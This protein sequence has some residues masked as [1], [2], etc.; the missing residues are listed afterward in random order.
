MQADTYELKQVMTPERRYIIPT[1]QRDYEW[2]EEGQWNLLF[3]DLE[4]VADRLAQAR[5]FAE[6]AGTPVLKA[7]KSVAP[8]FLGAI[9]CD[10]LPSP[11]GGL[12]LRAVIDGQQRL[13]TLQLLLRGVL[14]VLLEQG[15]SRAKQVRRL[16]ENPSDVVDEPHERF[17]LWPR[18]KDRDVW[19]VAMSDEPAPDGPHLYLQARAFFSKRARV[20]MVGEDGS[21]RTDAVVDALVGLFKLVVIDLEDNDDA[22][23]IFEVLNGRQTPLSA[24]DLVKNLLFLRGE[25]ADEKELE[26]LYDSYWAEFDEEWWKQKVGIGHA[27]RG[28]R[29]VLLSAWLTAASGSEVNVGH[30]Y[31]EV[32]TYLDSGDRK[33]EEILEELYRYGQAYKAVYGSTSVASPILSKAY[34]RL[35]LLKIQTAAPLFL[36]LR[37]VPSSVLSEADHEV[38]VA[39]IESWTL[40]R[41]IIGANT[42]GYGKA[43]VD[44]LK[45]AR[46]AFEGG[47]SIAAAIIAALRSGPNSLAWPSDAEVVAAFVS[48]KFYGSITQERI[49]LFLGSI[50]EHMQSSNPKTEAAQFDY[51]RLQI[52]HILPQSWR[53]H[54]AIEDDDPA[55]RTLAVQDRDAH[56]HRIGNLT[57]VSPTFNAS[58]SNKGWAMKRPEFAA[59]SKLQLNVDLGTSQ[60]WDEARIESRAQSLAS[61]ALEV[62]PSAEF[63]DARTY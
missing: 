34:R 14:D 28:R 26:K 13:T 18:R 62:W 40:R 52:E 58:V 7:D 48:N 6:L 19:P 63:L 56:V 33:T 53:D 43:F 59:Q 37:T 11:A 35:D 60:V 27:A 16:L 46:R 4:T 57:L 2:T 36:W 23:V 42:R 9:V 47:Q 29:D 55:R 5:E 25:L 22:Q 51:D 50:D 39:A 17:K 21:D 49:R 10:Q 15:S 24:S 8:H 20:A 61:V 45:E 30:L 32:R 31:K 44:V 41:A 1:F 12:D 54:W 3:E 38:A